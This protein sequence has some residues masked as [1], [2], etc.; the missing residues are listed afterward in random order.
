[1]KQKKKRT[2][3]ERKTVFFH[4]TDALIPSVDMMVYAVKAFFHLLRKAFSA[5]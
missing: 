2:S 4:L 1:M 5:V 3:P